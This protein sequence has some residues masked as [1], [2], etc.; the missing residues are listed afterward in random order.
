MA[1]VEDMKFGL[2]VSKDNGYNFEKAPNLPPDNIIRAIAYARVDTIIIADNLNNYYRSENKGINW[3]IISQDNAGCQQL[4]IHPNGVYVSRSSIFVSASFNKGVTWQ[5]IFPDSARLTLRDWTLNSF[6]IDRKGSILVTT[7]SGIYRSRTA[8]YSDWEFVSRGLNAA[9]F[10]SNEYTSASQLAQN[11]Q[12]GV[13][14]AASRGQSVFRSVPDLGVHEPISASV[15]PAA[16]QNYPNPF[17]AMTTI[18][19]KMNSQGHTNVKVF[20][21]LGR[22]RQTVF[23]GFMEK[24]EH[25]LLFKG[26]DLPA[27]NYIYVIERDGERTESNVMTLTK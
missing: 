6:F 5:N 13:F 21:L 25:E 1:A 10:D 15:A 7:D 24:G 18:R 16:E 20:D 8:P 3:A 9:D 4:A 12:T 26:D 27:G 22:S 17:S 14:F 19:V 23:S 2:M 11:K